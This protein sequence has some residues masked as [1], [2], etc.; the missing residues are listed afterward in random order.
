[1]SPETIL[2]LALLSICYWLL[3]PATLRK[4]V[5]LGMSV[6]VLYSLQ[7]MVY[8]IVKTEKGANYQWVA[9]LS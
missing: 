2:V 1:L 9:L 4:A 7:P 8:P 5:L 6:V 3:V